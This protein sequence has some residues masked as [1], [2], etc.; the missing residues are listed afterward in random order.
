MDSTTE[1]FIKE[2]TFAPVST[3]TGRFRFQESS[4]AA[5]IPGRRILSHGAERLEGLFCSTAE[6]ETTTTLFGAAHFPG[7]AWRAWG[8][9]RC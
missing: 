7:V 6:Q 1:L 8:S 2:K 3:K 4:F 9:R 5:R